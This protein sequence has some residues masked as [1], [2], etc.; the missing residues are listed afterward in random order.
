[1]AKRT[2][3]L[4]IAL[5]LA[6]TAGAEAQSGLIDQ[7]E[8]IATRDCAACHATGTQG[9]SPNPRAAAFRD[10]LRAATLEELRQSLA[11]GI[12]AGHPEMPRFNF[13]GSEVEA[14]LAYIRSL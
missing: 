3:Y 5:F 10:F 12:T 14:L 11:S 7:G 1:M 4:A 2:G 8:A 6:A 9:A 13:S